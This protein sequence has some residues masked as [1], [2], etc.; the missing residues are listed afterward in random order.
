MFAGSD[1]PLSLPAHLL[2]PWGG[3]Q[4]CLWVHR[5]FGESQRGRSHA[6]LPPSSP[7]SSVPRHFVLKQGLSFRGAGVWGAAST[8]AGFGLTSG[9][10]QPHTQS[11]E[12]LN[13][14]HNPIGNEGV[15]NLKNGLISNRS[16]LRLGLASSKLTCEGR[17]G[18]RGQAGGRGGTLGRRRG[19]WPALRS[20]SQARWPWR[21]SSPRAPA[22]CDWT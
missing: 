2:L 6:W 8:P 15:R 9:S 5:A 11:L 13:L 3:G 20:P 1:I 16:V 14:G 18:V 10:L 21:N 17:P 19:P 22:S 7:V 12:T 4:Q